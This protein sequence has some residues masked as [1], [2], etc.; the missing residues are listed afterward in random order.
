MIQNFLNTPPTTLIRTTAVL[1][2]L[3]ISLFAA[4]PGQDKSG[5]PGGVPL[6]HG[7]K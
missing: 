7:R 4:P 1:M 6:R 5:T 3:R 2:L